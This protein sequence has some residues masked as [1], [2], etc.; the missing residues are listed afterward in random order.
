[1]K[2]PEPRHA[3]LKETAAEVVTDPVLIQSIRRALGKYF[4]EATQR[5]P[6]IVPVIMEV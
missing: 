6:V 4:F 1:M 5:K 2:R 3:S